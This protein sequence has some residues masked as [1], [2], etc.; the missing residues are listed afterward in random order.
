MSTPIPLP[1]PTAAEDGSLPAPLE[2]EAARTR[3]ILVGIGGATCSGKTTLAKHLRSL[4]PN[5]FIIHQDDFAPPQATLPMHPTL[6]VQDWDSAPTALDWP[7]QRAF[8]HTVKRTA[9]LPA[10]HSSH[11]HLN[12]QTPVPL[13]EPVAAHWRAE[14]EKKQREVEEREGVRVVWGLVDGFLMYWDKEIVDALDVRIFLRV[15]YEVLKQ[16]REERV[17]YAT[18]EQ[19]AAPEGT[20]WRDPPGYFDELVWPAYLDAHRSIFENSD[21]V[22]GAPI[23]PG[24]IFIEP[25]K[26]S[27]T[28][29]VVQC[30]DTLAEVFSKIQK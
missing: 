8:L 2:A 5:S 20:F 13:D 3:V 7:R 16:R 14:L 24:L 29:L 22:N 27:M 11:D 10:T 6:N 25:L 1:L 21:P 18:A 28:E 15:P 9:R 26:T 19:L 23:L 30:C 4:L 17:G 12:V